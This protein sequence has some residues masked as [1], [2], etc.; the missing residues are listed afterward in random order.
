M[1]LAALSTTNKYPAGG[2]GQLS[3]VLETLSR[4]ECVVGRGFR[5]GSSSWEGKVEF[6]S[7]EYTYNFINN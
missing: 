7:E 3:R 5:A 2:M 6:K 4:D 1:W